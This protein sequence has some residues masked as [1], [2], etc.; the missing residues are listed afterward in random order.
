MIL[1]EKVSN[2]CDTTQWGNGPENCQQTLLHRAIDENNDAVAI[3][4]IKSGCDINSPRRPGLNGELPDE[5]KDKMCPIH[6]ACT[7]GQEKIVSALVDFRCEINIQDADGNT[8]L[9]VAILNQHSE[10]IE[11]LLKQ[12]NIDLRIK[13][14]AGQSPFATALM[15]KNNNATRLILKREPN[16]AEQ[17]DNKG[18]NFL[19]TAV[20]NSDIET[21]LSLIS[22]NVNVNS[23]IQDNLSKTSLHLA[24]EVGS[25]MI[26]RNLILAGANV[27][28][29]T[30]NKKTALHLVAECI[31]PSVATITSIFLENGI[32][33]NALDSASN[34]ALHIA[35]Q[36]AN[37][38]VIKVLLSHSDIDIYAINSKGMSP[39]HVLGVYGRENSSAILETFLEN[40]NDFNLDLKDTKGN[41]ALLL[42]Y[43]NGNGSLCRSLIKYGAAI[44]TYNDDGISI[45]NHPVATKQLMFKLLDILNKESPWVEAE[46]CLECR[47]KFS[48]TNRKHHWYI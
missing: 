14:N 40:F 48:I 18:R 10:I 39:L 7:W 19:H 32:N 25:E 6:L 21:V 28:D 47:S 15:R 20:L 33:T 44:G 4:L 30:N 26:I 46:F 31:H 16:A 34:N 5:A 9:H 24:V 22:V 29:L 23:R 42:A 36:N 43:Q 38:P 37:L 8:P 27:N 45:F 41:S 3:F 35:V 11:I 13:N 17:T 1:N 12:Q 2:R